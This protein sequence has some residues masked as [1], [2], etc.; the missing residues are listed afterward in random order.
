M[1][2]F[3]PFY[4]RSPSGV[5]IE[6]GRRSTWRRLCAT[7]PFQR[8]TLG[9][10]AWRGLGL[11]QFK[12]SCRWVS[13]IRSCGPRGARLSPALSQA[14]TEGRTLLFFSGADLMQQFTDAAEPLRRAGV[15]SLCCVPLRVHDRT[16]GVL[17]I[18]GL[19]PE[20][21][22]QLELPRRLSARRLRVS[23][24]ASA[25]GTDSE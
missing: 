21:F 7:R 25:T 17:C 3:V 16:L 14:F 24:H 2:P 9:T 12:V 23:G 8:R 1:D 11:P 6:F 20:T 22:D 13:D 18:G 4:M 19:Q 5:D 10:Q 15:R